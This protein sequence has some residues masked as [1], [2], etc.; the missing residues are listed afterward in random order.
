MSQ[1]SFSNSE[2]IAKNKSCSQHY[3]CYYFNAF[4]SKD[5]FK[6][7]GVSSSDSHT[8]GYPE[9]SMVHIFW[10]FQ[11]KSDKVISPYSDSNAEERGVE[12]RLSSIKVTFINIIISTFC[13]ERIGAYKIYPHLNNH[14]LPQPRI[15]KIIQRIHQPFILQQIDLE[16]KRKININSQ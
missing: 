8:V 7:E 6:C 3:Y 15:L 14:I 16:L 12:V 10:A 11:T 5:R 2:H 13:K 4:L 9:S 1:R